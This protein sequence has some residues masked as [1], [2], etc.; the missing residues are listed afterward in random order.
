MSARPLIALAAALAA[1]VACTPLGGGGDVAAYCGGA[2]AVYQYPGTQAKAVPDGPL[3]IFGPTPPLAN[4]A[5]TPHPV[6]L[7]IK[8]AQVP[9]GRAEQLSI[10]RCG[11]EVAVHL[12]QDQSGDPGSWPEALTWPPGVA[13]VAYFYALFPSAATYRFDVSQD[14]V[15]AGSAVVTVKEEPLR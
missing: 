10:A 4:V 5:F 2:S 9:L 11:D 13:D 6:R 3:W 14:G 1:G 15:R 12:S 8:P 7:G